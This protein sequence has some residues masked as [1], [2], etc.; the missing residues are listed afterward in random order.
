MRSNF[1]RPRP[2]LSALGAAA[3][4]A[5]DRKAALYVCYRQKRLVVSVGARRWKPRVAISKCSCRW[6]QPRRRDDG[7]IFLLFA[8]PRTPIGQHIGNYYPN[9]FGYRDS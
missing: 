6:L 1:I 7:L 8:L 3:I 5:R 4:T 9:D 2:P